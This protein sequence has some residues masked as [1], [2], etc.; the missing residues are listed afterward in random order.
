MTNEETGEETPVSQEEV[1][2][3][4]SKYPLVDI[5]MKSIFDFPS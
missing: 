1:D 2:E 4:L 5:E 3:I